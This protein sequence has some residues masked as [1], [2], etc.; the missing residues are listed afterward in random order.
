MEGHESP[1]IIRMKRRNFLGLVLAALCA[2]SLARK[3]GA[4]ELP[5]YPIDKAGNWEFLE[6]L[7][8]K[9][10][11]RLRGNICK[12][13][14]KKSPWA[15]LVTKDNFEAEYKKAEDRVMD[16][17]R[18]DVSRE[19]ESQYRINPAWENASHEV[20]FFMAKGAFNSPLPSP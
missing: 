1:I 15:D 3:F 10:S 4:E 9:D 17:V 2:P 20:K 6:E 12:Q 18:A 8:A 14:S 16:A 5:C 13:L 11:E 7:M 19:T